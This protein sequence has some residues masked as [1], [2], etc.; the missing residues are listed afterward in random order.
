MANDLLEQVEGVV[1]RAAVAGEHIPV[2]LRRWRKAGKP[3]E[4]DTIELLARESRARARVAL[5]HTGIGAH[6]D[7]CDQRGLVPALTLF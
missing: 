4:L 7:L 1:R 2:E 6:L 3:V 5:D